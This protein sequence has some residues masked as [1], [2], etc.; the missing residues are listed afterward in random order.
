M[1]RFSMKEIELLTGI[2]AHTLRIWEKRYG[3]IKPMR[4][5]TNI[6]YFTDE[7]LR[8]ILNI[9]TLN[10]AGIKISKI[11]NLGEDEIA[12]EIKKLSKAN[13]SNVYFNR[14]TICMYGYEPAQ[15]DEIFDEC[16]EKLGFTASMKDIFLPFLNQI[17]MMWGNKE[18]SPSNEHFISNMV[19]KKI[20]S[21]IDALPQV[22]NPKGA[23]LLFLP[24]HESHELGILLGYYQLKNKG[25]KAIYLGSNLPDESLKE[26]VDFLEPRALVTGFYRRMDKENLLNY[27][28]TWD[29]WGEHLPIYFAGNIDEVSM[30][31]LPKKCHH[32]ATLSA[33]DKFFPST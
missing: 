4:T 29:K 7:Q 6:R 20:F 15:F 28:N 3:I 19:R 32:L 27:L 11:A 33:L 17:G 14:L 16:V 31:E 18:I 30:E 24:Q 8:K 9:T 12:H 21:A 25:Y 2:K 26:A 5:D 10:K 23:V 1:D 13:D 22:E